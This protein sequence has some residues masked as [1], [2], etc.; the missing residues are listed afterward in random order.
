MVTKTDIKAVMSAL[1]KRGGKVRSK[2]KTEANRRN[3]KRPKKLF[4]K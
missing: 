1:G 4:T 2:A 3:G